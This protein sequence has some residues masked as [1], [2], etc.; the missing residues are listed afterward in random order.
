MR[1]ELAQSPHGS[2]GQ[3]PNRPGLPVK[4]WGPAQLCTAA[5]GQ[6]RHGHRAWCSLALGPGPAGGGTSALFPLPG[7][8]TQTWPCRTCPGLLSWSPLHGSGPGSEHPLP[9]CRRQNTSTDTMCLK[10]SHCPCSRHPSEAWPV[11]SPYRV[12]SSGMSPRGLR[13]PC[14]HSPV[15]PSPWEWQ[16]K[17][18][19]RGSSS[20]H[21]PHPP[22]LKAAAHSEVL[23]PQPPVSQFPLGFRPS[24]PSQ[25]SQP[26]TGTTSCSQGNRPPGTEAA[27]GAG[28]ATL[29][30]L[31]GAVPMQLLVPVQGPGGPSGPVLLHPLPWDPLAPLLG[32]N[33]HA[34]A[35]SICKAP[36][37][38]QPRPSAL[39][40][41]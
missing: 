33:N 37:C 14:P 9:R 24:L 7:V 16:H 19:T 1:A 36:A 15:C 17:A 13:I 41:A 12:P 38:C 25:S 6:Q 11:P 27:R 4:L 32:H 40:M 34:G 2:W 28:T 21:L 8:S 26:S 35:S 30:H 31:A 39:P 10:L 29:P 18:P 23:T 3:T 20:H 5:Q 22:Q